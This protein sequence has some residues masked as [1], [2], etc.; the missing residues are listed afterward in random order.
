MRR[1]KVLY[2]MPDCP[3]RK[4]AGNKTHTLQ[5]L[6][7]F[8]S[9]HRHIELDYVGERYWGQWT[10]NDIIGFK[11]TFP[12]CNLHVL[13]RKMPKKNKVKYFFKYKLPLY[14]KKHRR[15]INRERLPDNNTHLL[16]RSFN[17]LLRK[18]K[19]DYIIISYVTWATLIENNRYLNGA[20]L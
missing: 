13:E 16:Q 18:K 7:Y 5:L 14:F 17:K 15:L 11:E 3:V 2:F 19:Y 1:K 4:D 20:R 12:Y 10:E 9:K 8:S 6:K